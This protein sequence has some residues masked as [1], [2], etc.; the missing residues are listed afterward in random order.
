[1]Q[2]EQQCHKTFSDGCHP[3]TFFSKSLLP[4]ECNYDIYDREL[5]AIINALKANCQLLLGAQQKFLIRTDHNNLKYFKTPQKISPRQARWHEFLQDYNFEITH[6]PG[7]S[8]TIADLLSRRKDFEEGV[9]P[10]KSVTL[11]PENLFVN[12]EIKV[13]KVYLEDNPETHCKVLQE[14]YDSPISGHPGISNTLD[15]VK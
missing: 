3:I 8:N 9:N 7:K 5:L 1:M 11:L 2:L 12:Q 10:N 6:F 15:L 13:N 4:A 14:I